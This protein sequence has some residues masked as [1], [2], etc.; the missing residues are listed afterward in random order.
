M[1]TW[2]KIKKTQTYK[3]YKWIKYQGLKLKRYKI[4]KIK[5]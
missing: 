3:D 2:I 4:I 1:H 5:I